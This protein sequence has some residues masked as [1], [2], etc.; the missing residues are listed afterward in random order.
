MRSWKF[1]LP[2][3]ASTLCLAAQPDRLAG[4]IDS[5][6]RMPLT[7]N[8]HGFAQPRFDIG[9]TDGSMVLHGVTIAFRPSAAQQPALNTLLAQQQNSKSPNFHKWLTP[10]QFA[11]RFGM[12][13]NDIV[14]VSEWLESQSPNVVSIANSRNQISF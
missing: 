12:S 2:F 10:A 4:P 9:R 7:G 5:A 14:H 1:L 8:V 13:Q 6:Q 11:D 3:L